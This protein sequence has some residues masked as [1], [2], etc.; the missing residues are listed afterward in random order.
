MSV[1]AA[2]L[3]NGWQPARWALDA[4]FAVQ[5]QAGVGVGL[6]PSPDERRCLPP[7]FPFSMCA[8]MFRG[9]GIAVGG[10]NTNISPELLAVDPKGDPKGHEIGDFLFI[11]MIFQDF[12]LILLFS[13]IFLFISMSFQDFL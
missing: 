7:P 5:D 13:L 12:L 1:V 6:P 8:Q 9:S 3:V 10:G 2:R 11:S 4:P